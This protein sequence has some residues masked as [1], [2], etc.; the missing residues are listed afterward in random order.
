MG[1]KHVPLLEKTSRLAKSIEKWFLENRNEE[2]SF[3]QILNKYAKIGMSADTV[4]GILR[5]M[6]NGEIP[7]LHSTFSYAVNLVI[8]QDKTKFRIQAKEAGN[9]L[10]KKGTGFGRKTK[11]KERP[12]LPVLKDKEIRVFFHC[13]KCKAG[14]YDNMKINEKEYL[15]LQSTFCKKCGEFGTGHIT[16]KSNGQKYHKILIPS[17]IPGIMTEVL[18]LDPPSI[19]RQNARKE[20]Y[21]EENPQH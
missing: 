21:I 9:A 16:F 13:T 4:A 19:P 2:L 5:E 11:R 12:I 3:G 1:R 15:S 8:S 10:R 6:T 14:Y 18:T 7:I 17:D 20:T